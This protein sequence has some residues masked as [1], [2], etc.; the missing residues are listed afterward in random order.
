MFKAISALLRSQFAQ[1]T[2]GQTPHG[3]LTDSF[4][5]SD[6]GAVSL[7]G[8]VATGDSCSGRSP[9]MQ[10]NRSGGPKR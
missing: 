3:D 2:A 5:H 6:E 1:S 10:S 4:V 9:T 8:A 7:N